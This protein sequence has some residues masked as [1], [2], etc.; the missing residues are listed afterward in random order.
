MFWKYLGLNPLE[1]NRLPVWQFEAF[2]A[3]LE[4]LAK[5]QEQEARRHGKS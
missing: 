1:I 3:Q 2:A 4:K 5:E